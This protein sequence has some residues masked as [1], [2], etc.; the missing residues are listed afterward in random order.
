MKATGKIIGRILILL[1]AA[2]LVVAG[3]VALSKTS[4]GARSFGPE[5]G[6]PGEPFRQRP[7]QSLQ[8][9]VQTDAGEASGE[10]ASGGEEFRPQGG[11]RDRGGFAFFTLV[12]NLGLMA[13]TVMICL[14]IGRLSRLFTRRRQVA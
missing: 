13:I 7:N 6:P 2:A 3:L 12:K 9:G 11:E 5:G 10:N 1:A 14:G 8:S 4:L